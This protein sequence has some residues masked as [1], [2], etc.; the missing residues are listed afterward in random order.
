M[1]P[2]KLSPCAWPLEFDPIKDFAWP[3]NNERGL[4][5][6]LV[7]FFDDSGKESNVNSPYVCMAGYLADDGLWAQFTLRWQRQLLRYGI[8]NI[9]MRSLIPLQGDY[10]DLGW[11]TEKRNAVLAD[12]IK[13]I[14]ETGPVGFGVGV[15]ANYWRQIRKQLPEDAS[16]QKFCFA[17]ILKMV[18]TRLQRAAPREFVMMVFDA[19]REF[20]ATRFNTLSEILAMDATVRQYITAITFASPIVYAPL[21]AADVLAWETRKE[22]IQKVG[23]YESTARWNELFGQLSEML[24]LPMG[25]IDYVSELWDKE[26]IEKQVLKERK[27]GP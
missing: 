7:G 3:W 15:D 25:G 27:P 9:H 21:Q 2:E 23:G 4:R 20:A 1:T 8:S 16:V 10:K 24:P 5:L 11:D 14:R 17:R 19:D 18:I 6:V 26:E 13:I 22:L 12:F